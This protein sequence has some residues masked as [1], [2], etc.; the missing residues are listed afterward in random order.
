ML[1]RIPFF[2][3][4]L[5]LPHSLRVR[6]LPRVRARAFTRARVLNGGKFGFQGV[7][8]RD[9]A[10]AMRQCQDAGATDDPF[11]PGAYGGIDLHPLELV[12]FKTNRSHRL[13]PTTTHGPAADFLAPAPLSPSLPSSVPPFLPPSLPPNFSPPLFIVRMYV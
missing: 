6:A 8:F 5:R 12:F 1:R 3:P 4:Y 13:P 9:A 7:D 2:P 11:F 10:R